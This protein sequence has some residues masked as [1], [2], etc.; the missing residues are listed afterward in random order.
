MTYICGYKD[1][2][3]LGIMLVFIKVVVVGSHPMSM[4]SLAL[5]SYLGFSARLDFLPVE[6]LSVQLKSCWLL[7]K[8]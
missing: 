6:Q 4:T 5:S 7:L 1:K 8:C 2:S 3:S